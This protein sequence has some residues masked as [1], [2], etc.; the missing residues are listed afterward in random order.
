MP[1]SSYFFRDGSRFEEN[2]PHADVYYKGIWDC[3]N[4]TM[5]GTWKIKMRFALLNGKITYFPGTKGTWNMLKDEG[6]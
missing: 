3:K 1:V 5:Q 2:K 4:K 6:V